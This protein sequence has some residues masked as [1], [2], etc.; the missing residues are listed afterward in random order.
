MRCVG[1]RPLRDGSPPETWNSRRCET[2]LPSS[3]LSLYM[4]WKREGKKEEVREA[5]RNITKFERNGGETEYIYK[6]KETA[7]TATSDVF[8]RLVDHHRVLPRSVFLRLAADG[9]KMGAK[10]GRF[11]LIIQL[12]SRCFAL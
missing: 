7:K 2:H 5:Q 1:S 9:K 6:S 4:Y 3:S 12:L 11:R 8:E 10:D